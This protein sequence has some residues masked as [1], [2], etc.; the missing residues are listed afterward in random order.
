MKHLSLYQKRKEEKSYSLLLFFATLTMI[1]NRTFS[2]GSAV[3]RLLGQKQ[4]R[5][6]LVHAVLVGFHP[7]LARANIIMRWEKVVPTVH[8][9][10][11]IT[12]SLHNDLTLGRTASSINDHSMDKERVFVEI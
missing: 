7:P 6:H 8:L 3:G 2:S 1:N 11:T 9:T 10:R 12:R 4:Q 5:V